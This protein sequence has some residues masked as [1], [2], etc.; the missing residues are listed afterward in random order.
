MLCFILSGTLRY[1]SGV[2]RTENMKEKG[3]PIEIIETASTTGYSRSNSIIPTLDGHTLSVVFLEYLGKVSIEV[4][5]TSGGDSQI[6]STPT[7][8]GVIF[9][10]ANTGNYI[11]TITLPNG[12]V[13]YGEFEVTD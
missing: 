12:D 6:Q 10:I 5:T 11:I 1:A 9:Y 2:A 4:E 7:P 3:I 13:Y 8:N